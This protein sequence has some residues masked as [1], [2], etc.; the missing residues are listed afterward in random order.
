MLRFF[1]SSFA[2]MALLSGPCGAQPVDPRDNGPGG[3]QGR[4]E[5]PASNDRHGAWPSAPHNGPVAAAPPG[6]TRHV[7]NVVVMRPHG[8]WYHGYGPYRGDTQAY[9]WLAFTAITLA[10]LDILSEQQQ[11]AHEDAQIRAASAP[12]GQA[13]TWNDGT[14]GGSVV[15]LRDGTSSTGQYCREFQQ[16][17]TIGGRSEQAYGT[18]CRQ[19][20]GAWQVVSTR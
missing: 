6:R 5:R 4:D 16:T 2:V 13:I 14:A 8:H 20:D 12:I 11:R 10:V 17:V 18:A 7:N 9:Q 3:H 19:P 15:A 1:L